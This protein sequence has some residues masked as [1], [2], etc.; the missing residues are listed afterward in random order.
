M[1]HIAYFCAGCTGLTSGLACHTPV[2]INAA[3]IFA[4]STLI[5]CVFSR[6][7]VVN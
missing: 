3:A 5:A 6:K 7:K 1:K 2:F 4:L